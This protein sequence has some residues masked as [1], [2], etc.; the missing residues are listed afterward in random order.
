M[1]NK[2]SQA[3]PAYEAMCEVDSDSQADV[4]EVSESTGKQLPTVEM[5]CKRRENGIGNTT[6]VF[7]GG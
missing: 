4:Q 7:G 1:H 6:R 2:G 3:A 5:Y